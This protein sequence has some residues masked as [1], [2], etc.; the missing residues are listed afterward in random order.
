MASDHNTLNRPPWI[1]IAATIAAVAFLALKFAGLDF[2]TSG[3]I[4]AVEAVLLGFAV[5]ASVHHAELLA[6]RVGEPFGS[7]ILALAVTVIE[8]ALIISQ[9]NG[10]RPDVAFI[11]RDAVFATI[12]IVLNGIVGFALLIGGARH[13][14]Q[15]FSLDGTSAAVSVLATLA[16]LSLIL[17]NFTQTTPGP[18]YT[19]GQLAFVGIISLLLYGI[20]VFV[21]TVRHRDYFEAGGPAMNHT[22]PATR[23]VV[24]SAILLPLTLLV[25][26]L[27]AKTLSGPCRRRPASRGAGRGDRRDRAAARKHCLVAGCRPQ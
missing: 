4:V 19:S 16:T 27:M 10:A 6:V 25:V 14:E 11:G 8:A 23:M 15:K 2:G 13:H 3:A 21:Q 26:V 5:F 17:P 9:M 22:P 12:M 20:F 24:L 18:D 1:Y 7:I